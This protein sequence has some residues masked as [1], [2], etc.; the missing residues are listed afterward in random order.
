M[1]LWKDTVNLNIP[2]SEDLVQI[3]SLHF[4]PSDYYYFFFFLKP[5]WALC[6]HVLW[7][8]WIC[9]CL[10]SFGL[11]D[12]AQERDPSCWLTQPYFSL[13]RK[14]PHPCLWC[15]GIFWWKQ[16]KFCLRFT[17]EFINDCV[18]LNRVRSHLIYFLVMFLNFPIYLPLFF[19]PQNTVYEMIF[20]L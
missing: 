3:S 7:L 17:R 19:S 20:S 12:G 4:S 9:L 14:P 11:W 18:V 15:S 16:D 2:S 13:Q 8:P 10:K 5:Q 6:F 1:W